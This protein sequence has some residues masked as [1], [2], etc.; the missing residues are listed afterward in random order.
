[1]GPNPNPQ[2]WIPVVAYL[3]PLPRPKAPKCDQ[4]Y[5]SRSG[6]PSNGTFTAPMLINPSNHSR[7]CLYIFLAGPGQ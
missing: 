1:G 2:P 4:T 7:Q 5:V 6:G 3:E